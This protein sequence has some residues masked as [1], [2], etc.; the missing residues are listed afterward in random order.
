[1]LA[2]AILS[3]AGWQHQGD[4]M[5]HATKVAVEK[6]A[7]STG[8]QSIAAI[9]QQVLRALRN[10]SAVVLDLGRA[11]DLPLIQLIE[12]AR[13]YA[14]A[15]GKNIQLSGPAGDEL[16]ENL[17]RGGFL[18]TAPGRQFWLHEETHR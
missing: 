16:R 18:A 13:R 7:V 2:A 12:A 11:A 10:D 8:I 6:S 5:A 9:H 1:M 14:A 17:R 4:A 3:C 15:E